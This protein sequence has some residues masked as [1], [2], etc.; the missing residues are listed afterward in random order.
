M[1]DGYVVRLNQMDRTIC[2]YVAFAVIM[3]EHQQVKIINKDRG[4]Y[5]S[6]TQRERESADLNILI[7]LE[8]REIFSHAR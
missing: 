8:R 4:C 6:I 5:W 1:V 3:P 7:K 2:T